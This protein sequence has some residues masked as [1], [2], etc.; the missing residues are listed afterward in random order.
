MSFFYIPIFPLGIIISFTG[1]C[2]FYWLEKFNFANLYKRPEMLNSQITEFYNNFFII[3]L[4]VY[5]LGDYIFLSDVYETN[6]WSLVNIIIFSILIIIPYHQI[7]SIDYLELEE[8]SL[9]NKKFEDAYPDFH[10]DYERAN[11]MTEKEGLIKYFKEL[12]KKKRIHQ[13][14]NVSLL[15]NV[16][17]I[18]ILNKYYKN[19]SESGYGGRFNNNNYASKKYF[20][21]IANIFNSNINIFKSWNE[22]SIH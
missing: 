13:N 15:N 7:L 6:T 10:L 22:K 14:F 2:F 5:G 12:R 20:N 9:N 16:D 3:A 11:P 1:F 17:D 19:K 18:N 4:F 21:Q 8:S